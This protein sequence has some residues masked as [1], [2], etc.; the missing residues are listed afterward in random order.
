MTAAEA[1]PQVSAT[2]VLDSSKDSPKDMLQL[3]TVFELLRAAPEVLLNCRGE[4]NEDTDSWLEFRRA[5]EQQALG[6]ILLQDWS[7]QQQQSL[8]EV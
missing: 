2:P 6:Q 4:Q 5:A 8:F 3:W 1:A 7:E